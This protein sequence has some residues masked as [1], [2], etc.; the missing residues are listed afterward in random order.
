M[1]TYTSLHERCPYCTSSDGYC[2]YADGGHHCFSCGHHHDS[3]PYKALRNTPGGILKAVGMG[4]CPPLPEDAHVIGWDLGE[5]YSVWGWLDK[6]GLTDAEINTNHFHWS[7]AKELLI[8]P[9]YSTQG[10]LIM[11]QGRYFGANKKHPKYL[12]RGEKDSVLH[13]LGK[14]NPGPVVLVEDI[15]SAIRV[16]RHQPAMPLWGSHLSADVARRLA[17]QYKDAQVW[18]DYDKRGEAIKL[19][20]AHCM[21]LHI[22]PVITE[23]DPKCYNDGEIKEYLK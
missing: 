13:I 10:N 2:E 16:S 20:F 5:P 6:Y 7:P 18:L 17:T 14:E 15:I 23:L 9:I 3:S 1:P 21:R 19:A 8:F 22:E 11:W 4:G 12:T